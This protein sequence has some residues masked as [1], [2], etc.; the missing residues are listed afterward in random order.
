MSVR[1][2]SGLL[3]Q[4]APSINVSSRKLRVLLTDYVSQFADRIEQAADEIL[5]QTS[6]P[7][8]RR[9]ALLWKSNAMTACFRAALRPDPLAA[10][11]DI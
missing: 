2:T 5:S 3:E 10:Y 6:D 8:I 9:N 7:Q 11:L 4:T 1:S